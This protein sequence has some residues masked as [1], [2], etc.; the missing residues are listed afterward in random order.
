[1]THQFAGR[2]VV[3]FKDIQITTSNSTA[4]IR[5]IRQVLY[6]AFDIVAIFARWPN[7]PPSVEVPAKPKQARP[8]PKM[9]ESSAGPPPPRAHMRLIFLEFYHRTKRGLSRSDVHQAAKRYRKVL[10]DRH[11]ENDGF[12]SST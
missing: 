6:A 5:T 3:E 2:T 12:T 9:W 8:P 10:V 4:N 1:M 7:F 11:L